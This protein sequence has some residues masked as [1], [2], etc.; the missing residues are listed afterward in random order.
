MKYPS[1]DRIADLQQLIADLS[2]VQRAIHIADKGRFE[3]DV[4][5]SYGLALTCMYLAPKIAPD[6]SMEKILKYALAHDM[7]EVHS[8][9]TFAFDPAA[10]KT[11]QLREKNAQQKLAKEW[12]D[13]PEMLDSISAYEQRSDEEAKFVYTIDKI[14]PAIMVNL[15]EKSVF[16]NRNKVTRTMH[17]HEKEKKM[18]HSK[19]ASPYLQM[20]NEWLADPDYF[21]KSEKTTK[22]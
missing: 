18:K 4:E 20:L 22:K 3:N 17:E 9:D 2:E 21:Y 12:A 7:V 11:K 1:V 19:E 5:H 15:G 8:G 10:V 16:W 13:F 6:L 14:L